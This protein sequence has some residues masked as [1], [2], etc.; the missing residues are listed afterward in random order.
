MPDAATRRI[1]LAIGFPRCYFQCGR[2]AG[3]D[4][5]PMTL[6]TPRLHL[7]RLT[8]EDAGPLFA[9]FGD[10]GTMQFWVNGFDATA[11]ATRIR[12]EAMLQHWT[13]HGFGDWAVQEKASGEVIGICGLHYIERMTDVNLGYAF[14]KA[15]HGK[16]YATE[17]SRAALSYGFD[18]LMLK[19]IVAVIDPRNAPSIRVAEKCGL[20]LWQET[21]WMGHPRLIYSAERTH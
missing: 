13:D 12:V 7:R 9:C 5:I 14:R 3:L 1:H 18:R 6:E 20:Q 2:P 17:A 11:D 15:S 10:A 21:K 16:G 19:R 4:I 8:P